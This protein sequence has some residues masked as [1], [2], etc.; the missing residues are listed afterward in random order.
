MLVVLPLTAHDNDIIT[1]ERKKNS[2]K[3]KVSL[4]ICNFPLFFWDCVVDCFLVL[5]LS[6]LLWSLSFIIERIYM[7]L[8]RSPPAA[9][10]PVVRN[11]Q[12]IDTRISRPWW[13]LNLI[14]RRNS[15]LSIISVIRFTPEV[16]NKKQNEMN[17]WKRLAFSRV[18]AKQREGAST[19]PPGDS[20]G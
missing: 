1:E 19:L 6:L 14:F 9:I 7:N 3:K 8:L 12:E 5:F 13:A 20:I 10:S 15:S 17:K 16:E 11:C 18:E 2:R 4:L